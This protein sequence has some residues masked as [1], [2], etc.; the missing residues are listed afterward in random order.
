M[1]SQ[2][3]N[4]SLGGMMPQTAQTQSTNPSLLGKMMLPNS[5]MTSNPTQQPNSLSANHWQ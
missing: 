5:G 2:M 4:L 3:G 1:Q